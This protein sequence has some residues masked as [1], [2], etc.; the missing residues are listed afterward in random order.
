[1]CLELL[2][3]TASALG[4]LGWQRLLYW[5]RIAPPAAQ[6]MPLKD[7]AEPNQLATVR[8]SSAAQRPMGLIQK[9]ANLNRRD[10]TLRRPCKNKRRNKLTALISISAVTR[11]IAGLRPS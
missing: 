10:G 4:S 11:C 2:H 7:A 3:E 6:P 9:A 1:M 8:R 5:L